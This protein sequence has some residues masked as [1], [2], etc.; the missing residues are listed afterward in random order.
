MTKKI[1]GVNPDFA[2][3]DEIDMDAEDLIAEFEQG[4]VTFEELKNIVGHDAARTIQERVH[5]EP[6]PNDPNSYFDDPSEFL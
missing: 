1:V 5:G 2:D 4:E 3:F 6:D